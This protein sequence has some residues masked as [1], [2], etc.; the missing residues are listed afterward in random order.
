MAVLAGSLVLALLAAGG[1]F[2]LG[3]PRGHVVAA[4][5]HLALLGAVFGVLAVAVGAATGSRVLARAV[6]AGLAVL[7]YL[8]DGLAPL[9]GW[10]A[11]VR[12]L[13]PF[14]QPLGHQPLLTGLSVRGV[15]VCAAL[16]LALTAAAVPAF[17]R[18]DVAA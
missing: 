10:P 12:V 13:S 1:L 7:A 3:L 5:V 6:P 16:V 17:G 15:V 9:V 18:R 4:G 14:W 11:P 8:L 2:G